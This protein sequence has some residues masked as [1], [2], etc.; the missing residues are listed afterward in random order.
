[1]KVWITRDKETDDNFV[2]IWF[3]TKKPKRKSE[4]GCISFNIGD[5]MEHPEKFSIIHYDDFKKIFKISI[6]KGSCG[7]YDLPKIN[8]VK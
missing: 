8:K 3:V 7:R 6:K 5:N 4:D 2:Y 1:M